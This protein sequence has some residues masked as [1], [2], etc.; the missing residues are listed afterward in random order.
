MAARQNPVD[1]QA[2]RKQLADRYARDAD[3][4]DRM[5]ANAPS[6]TVAAGLKRVSA[7]KRKYAATAKRMAGE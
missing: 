1:L 5:A 3:A 2:V 4:A 7:R 6:P